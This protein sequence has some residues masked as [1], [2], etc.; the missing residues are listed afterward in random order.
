MYL[1]NLNLDRVAHL[2]HQEQQQNNERSHKRM[3]RRKFRVSASYCRKVLKESEFNK[4]R[5]PS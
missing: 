5:T 1:K 3:D 2:N 4:L